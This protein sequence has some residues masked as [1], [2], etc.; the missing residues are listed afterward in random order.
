MSDP[1]SRVTIAGLAGLRGASF[2]PTRWVHVDQ[3]RIDLFAEATEDRQWIHVDPERAA[4][5]P[6][7]GTIAHGYLT[8]SVVGAF[9]QELFVV[10]DAAS[11]IN[12]GLD[13]VR[14]PAPVPE[15]ARLRATGE[16]LEVEPAGRGVQTT[17]RVVVECDA[18]EKPVCVAEVLTRFLPGSTAEDARS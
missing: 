1:V 10:T 8:L 6:F 13:R 2:G 14:F 12:Y 7:G 11:I 5:G 17:T 15:G 4:S 3:R 18:T 16:L 9:M